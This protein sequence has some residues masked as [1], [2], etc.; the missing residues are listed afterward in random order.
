MTG[1]T[2]AALAP[3]PAK[4]LGPDPRSSSDESPLVR[5]LTASASG[6]RS[7]IQPVGSPTASTTERTIPRFISSPAERTDDPA[8]STSATAASSTQRI[9]SRAPARRAVGVS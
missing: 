7:A 2:A 3:P 4:T 9:A 5:L 8:S 6:S 1:G